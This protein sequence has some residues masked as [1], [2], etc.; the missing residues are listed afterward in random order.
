MH[1]GRVGRTVRMAAVA[2]WSL[3]HFLSS[4]KISVTFYREA[5]VVRK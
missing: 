2:L 5:Y 3:P 1:L 4:S